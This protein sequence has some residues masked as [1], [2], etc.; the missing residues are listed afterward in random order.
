MKSL[1]A[2]A[3]AALAIGVAGA[4]FAACEE[5]GVPLSPSEAVG[6]WSLESAGHTLC[7]V[8]LGGEK[9]SGGYALQAAPDCQGA[10]PGQPVAWTPTR[11]GVGLVDAS[12]Q[13][14]I[15]FNRWSNSL[16]VSHQSSG[17][18]VQLRR[19]G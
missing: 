4:A 19:R 16:F 2:G 13:T 1:I 7:V 15:R 17:V 6:S 12:G 8:K 10:L 18:D 3:C 9:A 11:D 5:A 14:F